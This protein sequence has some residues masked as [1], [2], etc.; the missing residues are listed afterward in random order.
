MILNINTNALINDIL[1]PLANNAFILPNLHNSANPPL[2]FLDSILHIVRLL[3]HLV[4]L[5][6][7]GVL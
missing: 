6:L 5:A 3:L 1:N 7:I 2:N 4:N